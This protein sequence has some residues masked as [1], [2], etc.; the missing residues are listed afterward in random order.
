M[1]E[2]ARPRL[3]GT[4]AA[5]ADRYERLRP[6][7]P[8]EAVRFCVPLPSADVVDVG[9]G[10]GKLTRCLLAEGH[11]VI[12][13]EPSAAMRRM[14]R[15]QVP[16]VRVLD[17]TAERTRLPGHS[18]DVVTFGQ[19]WHWVDVPSASA[20][21]ERILRPNGWVSMLWSMLDDSVPWVARVQEAMHSTARAWQRTPGAREPA[22]ERAPQGRFGA[23]ERHTVSW[24]SALSTADIVAMVTTRS[25]YLEATAQE[26]HG[27]LERVR[28]AVAVEHL[29][30]EDDARVMVP[31]VTTC[32]RYRHTG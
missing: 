24:S 19:S 25:Y 8:L 23:A 30:A 22:W 15:R 7:H 2:D 21:L 28:R 27:L 9:A 13:I 32:L 12:A 3:V 16:G 20:E 14:M 1:T 11:Q 10:T 17:A 26:Q 18:V 31:Y 5:G 29:A 4:F 6:T